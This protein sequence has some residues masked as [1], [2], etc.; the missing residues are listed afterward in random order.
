MGDYYRENL[1]A[2]QLKRCYDIAPLRVQRYLDEEV[3]FVCSRL[4][5]DDWVLELGCGYG[6]VLPALARCAGRVIGIDNSPGSLRFG[7]KQLSASPD[8]YLACMDATRL[9]FRDDSFDVV[10]CIQNGVSAFHV[11][12]RRLFREAVRVAVPGGLVLFSTYSSTFWPDR[13][14]W[15]ELQAAEGLLGEIDHERTGDGVIVCKDGFTA[16]TPTVRDFEA[17]I[18]GLDVTCRF[19]EVDHSSLFCILKKNPAT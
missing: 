9:A 2:E 8:V 5:P 1:A 6:R 16:T 12:P 18:K 13:L 15:F 7:M 11:D 14:E 4:N 3:R 19:E 17:N 10:V